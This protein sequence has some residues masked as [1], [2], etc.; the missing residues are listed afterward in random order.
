MGQFVDQLVFLWILKAEDYFNEQRSQ[1]KGN[2][3]IE[4]RLTKMSGQSRQKMQHVW[5]EYLIILTIR[6][7]SS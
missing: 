4:K 6:M 2:K 5:R 3:G 7:Y 1:R